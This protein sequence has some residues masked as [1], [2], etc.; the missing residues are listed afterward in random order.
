MK[1]KA[2]VKIINAASGGGVVKHELSQIRAMRSDGIEVIG[3]IFSGRLINSYTS[4]I[5]EVH[6][7]KN[8]KC[9]CELT[10]TGV[11]KKVFST[12]SRAI[13][14]APQCYGYLRKVRRKY[15]LKALMCTHWELLPLVGILAKFLSLPSYW[16]MANCANRRSFRLL[17]ML[18]IKLLSI[19]VI[20]NSQYSLLTV[21]RAGGT[22]IYPGYDDANI[23]SRISKDSAR[24]KFQ[25]P[26]APR[27]FLHASRLCESK[28]TDLVISAFLNSEA[29]RAGELLV[30]AGEFN[31][32]QFEKDILSLVHEHGNN[33]IMFLGEV[34]EMGDL[35][36]CC[37][38]F[39]H[40]RRNPEPFG[41]A[42]AEAMAAKIPVIAYAIGGP[43]EML[44][45]GKTG[46]LVSV[47]TIK[48]YTA[49]YDQAW[50]ARDLWS[51]MGLE[52][53]KAIKGLEVSRQNSRL[54]NILFAQDPPQAG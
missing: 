53:A 45:D 50:R 35:L 31:D 5:K 6:I 1:R 21:S 14:V 25:I 23:R 30:I 49:A 28:A 34:D 40:G 19:R 46:W 42:V 37:D 48:Q 12:I 13:F 24:S 15:D 32:E 3:I 11:I 54:L 39:V 33:Q 16:H 20:G 44:S 26:S 2:I 43:S 38:I 27:V 10:N 22:V 29:F 4:C 9:P 36:R 17:L 51:S 41:I 18:V 7:L 47:A 8:K 52:G